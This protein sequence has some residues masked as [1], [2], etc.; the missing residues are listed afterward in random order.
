[1]TTY[2]G[3]AGTTLR[4]SGALWG[5]LTILGSVFIGR[6]L[7]AGGSMLRVAAAI[8]VMIALA[9]PALQR[10]KAALT[11]LFIILPVLGSVRHMFLSATGAAFL[12]PLL[13]ISSAVAITVFV[14]LVLSGEMD[15]GGTLLAKM[16]FLLLI[17]GLLHVFNPGQRGILVGLTGVMVNLIPIGFFFI[18]RTIADPEFTRR[19]TRIVIGVG[20]AAALY[21]L[22]QVFVGFPGFE[23]TWLQS[24]GAQS[25]TVGGTT[26]PHS[27]FNNASEYAAYVHIAF[28]VAFAWLLF[29]PR[30]KRL[31]FLG[32]AALTGYAGFLIGSRGFTVKVVLAIIVLLAARQRNKLLAGGVVIILASLVVLWSASTTSTDRIQDKEEGASQLIEQQFRALADPFD[33][34]K[35]TLPIHFDQATESIGY[36]ITKQPLGLGTGAPTRG[37]AKFAGFT[38]SSELDIGDAFLAYGIAGGA[39]YLFII[40]LAL[41]NASRARRA[42]PGPVWIAIWAVLLSSV[43]GWMNGGQYAIGP[44]I[45]FFV[46]A[47]D[48]A[49][50]RMRD[51]GLLGGGGD[52]RSGDTLP[53]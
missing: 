2:S 45:W 11:G 46:G 42:L 32:V 29:S 12:D 40:L 20:I 27:F 38:A 49:Y 36:A 3:S 5:V 25:A 14:S 43:G 41:T 39:L 44:L 30:S 1:M 4:R 13:L 48:G 21:G 26:R 34:T 47:S 52:D 22:Y 33:R 35:S 17:V 50:K 19:V 53:A 7:A 28:V 9:I 24:Q 51:R 23:L 6:Q 18:G 15:W 16:V 8:A 37:G 31:F 10:P